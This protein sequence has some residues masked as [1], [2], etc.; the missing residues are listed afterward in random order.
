MLFLFLIFFFI[1]FIGE[2]PKQQ[3]VERPISVNLR[4][5]TTEGI[6]LVEAQLQNTTSEDVL[7]DTVRFATLP[8]FVATNM[9][10][11]LHTGEIVCFLK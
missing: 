11:G 10:A 1:Y 6:T 9:S 8:G 5:K 4:T 2:H 3:K 7:L